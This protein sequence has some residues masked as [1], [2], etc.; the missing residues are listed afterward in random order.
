MIE[1]VWVCV[2]RLETVYIGNEFT[3]RDTRVL[4][5]CIVVVLGCRNS[6]VLTVLFL[7]LPKVP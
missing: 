7:L 2:L 6:A 3:I 1:Y 4:R 5:V